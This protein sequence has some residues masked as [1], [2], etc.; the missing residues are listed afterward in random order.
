MELIASLATRNDVGHIVLGI[1]LCLAA[2]LCVFR[3]RSR[4][5]NVEGMVQASWIFLS[6]LEAGAGI[7]STQ[8]I[9]LMAFNPGLP[10]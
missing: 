4:M 2:S 10:V 6:G 1:A 7:W 5:R 9:V 8:Y 3:L